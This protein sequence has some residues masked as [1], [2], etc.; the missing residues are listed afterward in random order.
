VRILVASPA[1]GSGERSKLLHQLATDHELTLLAPNPEWF[2]R[3]ARQLEA[4]DGPV[5]VLEKTYK[6]RESKRMTVIRNS[7][8]P[9]AGHY[10]YRPAPRTWLQHRP[11]VLHIEYS[12]WTPEFW[13]VV[14]PILVLRPRMPIVLYCKKNTRCVPRGLRGAL[15]R[16]LTRIALSRV[17]LILATSSMTA[18]LYQQ[19]SRGRVPIRVQAHLAVDEAL[20]A[21]PA[22]SISGDC[23]DGPLTVGFVGSVSPHKGID[24]LIEAIASTRKRLGNDIR[25][26]MVGPMRD[27]RLR[28][29]IDPLPWVEH[30]EQSSHS[31]IPRILAEIDMFVLPSRIL[32]DHEEHDAQAM[33]EAMAAERPCIGS[34]SGVIPDLIQ[35][36]YTGLLFEPSD[37]HGLADCLEKLCTDVDLRRRL[38]KNAREATIQRS[39]LA[40]L[41]AQRIDAYREA[42]VG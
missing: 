13:S 32:P 2:G 8:L 40:S 26:L 31:E 20:F 11:D 12:P 3:Y 23:G 15:E 7:P 33:V 37:V 10:L 35:D 6:N 28:D 41:A 14:L 34:R 18:A 29:L 39:G 9:F 17:R 42:T 24:D 4:T 27:A 21:P 1:Y 5:P 38:G 30:R 36:R 25:L 22:E 16:I 19:L